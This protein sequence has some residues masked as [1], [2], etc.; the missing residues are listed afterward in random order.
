MGWII[1]NVATLDG[2]TFIQK[3]FNKDH[4]ISYN[5]DVS[6][7]EE[8]CILLTTDCRGSEQYVVKCPIEL[9]DKAIGFVD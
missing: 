9:L 2:K 6:R 1:L 3:R 8:Y 5:I 4:I 7:P